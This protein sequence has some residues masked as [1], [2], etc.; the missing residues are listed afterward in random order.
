M[1][2]RPPLKI[3]IKR[4]GAMHEKT[5]TPKGEKIPVAKLEKEKKSSDPLTRKQAQFAINARSWNKNK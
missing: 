1:A 4:P 3:E 2:K 5:K